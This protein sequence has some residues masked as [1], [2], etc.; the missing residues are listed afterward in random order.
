MRISHCQLMHWCRFVPF[1]KVREE[2]ANLLKQHNVECKYRDT[3]SIKG[4][5]QP[6][7]VYLIPLKSGDNTSDSCQVIISDIELTKPRKS[8]DSRISWPNARKP[9]RTTSQSWGKPSGINDHLVC[10]GR[11]GFLDHR[12]RERR[13]FLPQINKPIILEEAD[14]FNNVLN[15]MI[16]HTIGIVSVQSDFR[17]EHVYLCPRYF[18]VMDD[19]FMVYHCLHS[20]EFF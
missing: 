6:M 18:A 14:D 10:Y 20:T 4:K 1:F 5:K 16:Y 13:N 3:I 7:P 8:V 11:G 12:T 2:T 19:N 15:V 9:Q 17:E